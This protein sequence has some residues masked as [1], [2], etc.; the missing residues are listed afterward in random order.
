MRPCWAGPR[1]GAHLAGCSAGRRGR[2]CRRT[3][4]CG[5]A[6]A[7][8]SARCRAAPPAAWPPRRSRPLQSHAQQGLV[9]TRGKPQHKPSGRSAALQGLPHRGNPRRQPGLRAMAHGMAYAS[10]MASSWPLR[11]QTGPGVYQRRLWTLCSAGP[12]APTP[13]RRPGCHTAGCC[14]SRRRRHRRRRQDTCACRAGPV[15]MRCSPMLCTM[16][17]ISLCNTAEAQ[18]DWQTAASADAHR[19]VK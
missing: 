3:R 14:Q 10:C 16:C 12:A 19:A 15:C 13:Q 9:S 8:A 6:G 4:R 5:R 17:H 7:A 11:H 1:G 2:W 18:H